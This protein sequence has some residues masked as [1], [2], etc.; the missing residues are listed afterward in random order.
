MINFSIH[1]GPSADMNV[2][3]LEVGQTLVRLIEGNEY[4]PF[5][6]ADYTITK[7]LKSRLVVQDDEG[8]EIR[9]IVQNN[10]R[11]GEVTTTK[12]GEANNWRATAWKFATKNDEHVVDAAIQRRAEVLAAKEVKNQAWIAIKEITGS[13]HP[14]VESVEAA[15]EK[16][17]ALATSLKEGN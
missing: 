11:A 16:L 9:I 3:N 8:R 2:A 7:L 15:I 10:Y 1:N 12:E 14:T 17:Q 5:R 4:N 13:M 6:K